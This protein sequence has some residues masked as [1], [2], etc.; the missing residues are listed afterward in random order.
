MKTHL[1]FAILAFGFPFCNFVN[2][3]D[4][5]TQNEIKKTIS[6]LEFGSKEDLK[7]NFVTNVN[8]S[9]STDDS[10]KE[11][12][13]GIG[14]LG[15]QFERGYIYGSAQFT[16][17]SQNKEVETDSTETKIFGTN[18]LLPENSSGKISNFSILL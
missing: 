6:N 1:Y 13:A 11:S 4:Q 9:A 2:A 5:K 16:V 18:L 10:R 3:K 14:T 12:K 7:I 17:F 8:F 15:L